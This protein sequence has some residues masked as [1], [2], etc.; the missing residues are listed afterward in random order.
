MAVETLAQNTSDL[1]FVAALIVD[2]TQHLPTAVAA[3]G[4]NLASLRLGEP[5]DVTGAERFWK[6]DVVIRTGTPSH[7]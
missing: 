7:N 5:H 3:A 1:P 4:A 2:P 6:L